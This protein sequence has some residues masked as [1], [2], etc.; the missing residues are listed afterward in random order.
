MQ[1]NN[2]PNQIN[3]SPNFTAIRIIRAT[4]E[5][6]IKLK[7]DYP[8]FCN[9]NI[10]F[11][12]ESML[13][14]DFYNSLAKV[15]KKEKMSENWVIQNAERHGLL[16]ANHLK[17]LPMYAITGKDALKILLTN[18]KRGLIDLFSGT[19]F[20]ISSEVNIGGSIP[21]HLSQSAILKRYADIRFP[22][23]EKFIEKNN[24][25]KIDFT[26]FLRELK[27]GKLND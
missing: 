19:L 1:I 23:F 27:S 10:V 6:F 21:P 13:H 11:M 20:K 16:E 4:P 25:K 26:E 9:K 14:S 24:A 8:N 18:F 2:N 7:K 3:Y 5:Q 12:A 15:A 17:D 22:E